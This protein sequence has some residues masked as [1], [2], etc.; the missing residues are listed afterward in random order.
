MK[1]I[2]NFIIIL[3]L[4]F[5]FLRNPSELKSIK[6]ISLLRQQISLQKQYNMKPDPEFN[7]VVKTEPEENEPT[8]LSTSRSADR[9]ET[10]RVSIVK[11][12]WPEPCL[13]R[14]CDRPFCCKS[15]LFRWRPEKRK[16]KKLIHC[17]RWYSSISFCTK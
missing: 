8:D 14:I 11:T 10:L 1:K 15:D 9:C 7:V 13:Q 6:N 2:K 16:N 5:R 4:F 17:A 12:E 3:F